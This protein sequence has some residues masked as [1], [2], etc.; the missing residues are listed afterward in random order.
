MRC[1]RSPMP[2][3]I[4]PAF[5][6]LAAL[7]LVPASASAQGSAGQ[8]AQV[9]YKAGQVWQYV[10]GEATITVLKVDDL[11]KFGRVIH[12][13]A[14]NVPVSACAGLHLTRAIEHVALTEKM[15]RKSSGSLVRE[16]ADLPDSYFESYRLWQKQKK[17]EVLKN[18]TMTD[19]IRRT[20]DLPLICNFLPAETA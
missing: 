16:N 17:P 9:E 3:P 20:A 6:A 14:D 12:V 18:Q 10:G 2:V 1:W 5:V 8:D 7:T 15:M 4:I 19:V 11:P 13:R